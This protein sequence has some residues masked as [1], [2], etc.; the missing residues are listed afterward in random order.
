MQLQLLLDCFGI[1][2]GR[3]LPQESKPDLKLQLELKQ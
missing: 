1:F 2:I 3:L